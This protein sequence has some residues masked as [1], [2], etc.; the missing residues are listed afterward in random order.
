LEAHHAGWATDMSAGQYISCS[1]HVLKGLELY[2][3]E[4]H[5]SHALIY[6][7]HDP[8]VCGKGQRAMMLWLLGYPDQ[9]AKE[10]R[11]GIELAETLTHVPSRGHALWF[12]AAVYQ[13]RRD[14][15]AVLHCAERL[16][17]I[18]SEH[19]LGQYQPIGHIMHGWAFAHLVDMDEGLSEL[20]CA[21]NIAG[22][23]R[24][25]FNAILAGTEL[26]AGNFELA[27]AALNDAT[28]ICDALGETFW[29]A[30][31]LCV[32]GDLARARSADDWRAA[33]ERYC[34][35]IAIAREQQAKSLELRA[36]TDLAR[37]WREQ[38]QR[39]VLAKT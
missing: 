19:G 33:Q 23:Q 15:P 30:G 28:A 12:A 26:R 7:G 36:A 20:R 38:G 21:P 18:C 4:E 25:Y 8:A 27:M 22:T 24:T 14:A 2:D 34:E 16:L 10:A 5:R 1:E 3:R 35:A 29:R 9:A 39:G 6:G 13:L 31:L 37:L 11:E 32:E 17:A